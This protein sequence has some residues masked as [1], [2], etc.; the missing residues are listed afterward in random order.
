MLGQALADGAELPL[1]VTLGSVLPFPSVEE[2]RKAKR[3]RAWFPMRIEPT[4]AGEH[5]AVSRNISSVGLLMATATKL[6]LGAPVTLRFRMAPAGPPEHVVPGTI[7]RFLSNEE[8]PDGL[9]PHKVA[10]EFDEPDP[11]LESI[12][13]SIG[14]ES[15]EP[16]GD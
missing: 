15:E 5:I 11:K 10:V 4:D 7:V 6:E 9:W 12:L 3:F 8:D 14:A 1:R 13:L 2:R 16:P